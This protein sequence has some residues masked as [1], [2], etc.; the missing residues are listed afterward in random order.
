[1]VALYRAGRQVEA[2]DVYRRTRTVLDDSLG[3]EPSVTLR[4]LHEQVLRQDPSL[5]EPTDLAPPPVVAPRL[6]PPEGPRPSA[7]SLP[8]VARPLVGRDEELG[9]LIELHR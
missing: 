3:L 7:T 4:S 2:L 1:M 8:A 9:A 5:G 6:R